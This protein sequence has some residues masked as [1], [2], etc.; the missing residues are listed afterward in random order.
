MQ[1]CINFQG[2]G[3]LIMSQVQSLITIN[4]VNFC[5]SFDIW[6]YLLVKHSKYQTKHFENLQRNWNIIFS[7]IIGILF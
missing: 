1:K 4:L 2:D 6:S 7:I 3:V 5:S